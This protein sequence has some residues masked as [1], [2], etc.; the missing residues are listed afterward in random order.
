MLDN[1]DTLVG[2]HER[3]TTCSMMAMRSAGRLSCGGGPKTPFPRPAV[4]HRPS[5]GDQSRP[6][7]S[8][9]SF[10]SPVLLGHTRQVQT[11]QIVGPREIACK[12]WAPDGLAVISNRDTG[13]GV[14]LDRLFEPFFTTKQ[15]G[16][17]V[18]LCI[19]HTII[20]AHGGKISA[21]SHFSGAVSHVSLH[22]AK[23]ARSILQ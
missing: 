14:P 7:P 11:G 6:G 16:M 12:S 17:G 3:C 18:R 19:A 9:A 23:T 21:E 10:I 4:R 13:P 22:P 15:D 2:S 20:E 1:A 5:A 8:R